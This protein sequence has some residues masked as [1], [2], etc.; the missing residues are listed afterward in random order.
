MASKDEQSEHKTPGQ[1]L[2]QNLATLCAS[3]SQKDIGVLWVH[4]YMLGLHINLKRIHYRSVVNDFL[5][6][7][8]VEDHV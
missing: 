8:A 2:R 7:S 5:L 3:G 4:A 1:P 6:F